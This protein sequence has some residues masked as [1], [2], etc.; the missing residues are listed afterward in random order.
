VLGFQEGIR[1]AGRKPATPTPYR[2]NRCVKRAS[3]LAVTDPQRELL[4]SHQAPAFQ[5][6]TPL[7]AI[8]LYISHFGSPAQEWLPP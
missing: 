1:A 2:L 3:D 5:I 8:T 4:G 6:V 7:V